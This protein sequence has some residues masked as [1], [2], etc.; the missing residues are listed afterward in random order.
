VS[1][2][3]GT[4][5]DWNVSALGS[6]TIDLNMSVPAGATVDWKVS[7]LGSVTMD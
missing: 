4:T 2:P 5:V 1:V 7:V 6:V 3:A